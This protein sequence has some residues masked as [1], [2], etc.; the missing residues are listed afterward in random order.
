V[1]SPFYFSVL[2]FTGIF[3]GF[4]LLSML[5]SSLQ[6]LVGLTCTYLVVLYISIRGL[7]SHRH[8]FIFYA[9]AISHSALPLPLTTPLPLHR[10]Q[11]TPLNPSLLLRVHVL[12]YLLSPP[13]H[14]TLT[15]LT[16]V[17]FTLRSALLLEIADDQPSRLAKPSSCPYWQI[18]AF[19]TRISFI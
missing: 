7:C 9:F 16:F 14:L 19:I 8:A 12:R 6:L 10:T 3:F 13:P 1:P 11:P 4:S 17:L 15:V 18:D 2:L 5:L